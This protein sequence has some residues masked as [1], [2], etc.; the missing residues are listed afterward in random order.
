MVDYDPFLGNY[1][2]VIIRD[3]TIYGGFATTQERL[4]ETK[5]ENNR[6]VITK[7]IPPLSF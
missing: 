2:G 4:R 1:S 6:T 7:L 5:G 3:N